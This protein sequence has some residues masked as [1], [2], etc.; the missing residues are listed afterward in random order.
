MKKYGDKK[1]YIL[2]EEH[3][4]YVYEFSKSTFEEKRKLETQVE[5]LK[6]EVE[7][8]KTQLRYVMD[9]RMKQLEGIDN[10]L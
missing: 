2:W 4:H 8:L 5:D 1:E 7:E 3:V 10:G 6:D 9:L